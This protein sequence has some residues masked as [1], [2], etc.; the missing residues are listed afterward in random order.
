MLSL[1]SQNRLSSCGLELS[2]LDLLSEIC[3]VEIEH[4]PSF[5]KDKLCTGDH[6]KKLLEQLTIGHVLFGKTQC[7]IAEEENMSVV[8]MYVYSRAAVPCNRSKTLSE[9]DPLS[10]EEPEATGRQM[11]VPNS[12]KQFVLGYLKPK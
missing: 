8:S 2:A 7:Q 10:K 9:R 5:R 11:M 3:L 4:F 1:N 12:Y 6:E